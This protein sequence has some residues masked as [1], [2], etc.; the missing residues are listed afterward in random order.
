MDTILIASLSTDQYA[1]YLQF[2]LGSSRETLENQGR[3]SENRG[4]NQ[5]Q[6]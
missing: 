6:D 1:F 5:D 3:L 2:I 4:I